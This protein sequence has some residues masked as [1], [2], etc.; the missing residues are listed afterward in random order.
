MT[1]KKNP[2]IKATVRYGKSGDSGYKSYASADSKGCTVNL[3]DINL[4]LQLPCPIANKRNPKIKATVRY[5]S[6]GGS[7]SESYA[8]ADSKSCTLNLKDINLDLR[9]PCP[10]TNKKNPKIKA[11][12]RYGNSGSSGSNSYASADSKSCTVNLKD[13]NLNLQIPCPVKGEKNPKVRASIKYGDGKNSA[14]AN[15]ASADSQGCT[16]G[17]KDASLNLQIPCPV[18]PSYI[19]FTGSAKYGSGSTGKVSFADEAVPGTDDCKRKI[20]L[21]ITF[22]KGGSG[23]GSGALANADPDNV[24]EELRTGD[25]KLQIKSWNDAA[26]PNA[27]TTIVQDITGSSEATDAVVARQGDKILKY[28]KPGRLI[29]ASDARVVFTQA[30][31]GNVVIGVYY[32]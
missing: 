23:G 20:K 5:G 25:G 8:S 1:N 2:R 17:L 11:T 26:P 27:S 22:P 10:V 16:M 15:Y 7:E 32:V 29:S 6:S 9:I 24:S 13:I 4:D 28:K 21:T 12:V 14:S 3:K 30:A 31:N 18:G 19:S